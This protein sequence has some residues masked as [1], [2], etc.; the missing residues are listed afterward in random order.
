M[1]VNPKKPLLTVC[2]TPTYVAPEILAENGYGLEVDNWAAGVICYIPL[3]GFPPFR[4]K[5][6]SDSAIR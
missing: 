3:C 6:Q 5:P 1:K 2:G 4:N